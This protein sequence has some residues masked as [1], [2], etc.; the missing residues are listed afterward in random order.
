M[1][2]NARVQDLIRKNEETKHA[3]MD[4]MEKNPGVFQEYERLVEEYNAGVVGIKHEMRST[5]MTGKSVDFGGGFR[6][7]KRVRKGYDA[8][9]LV[10]ICPELVQETGVVTK[11]DTKAVLAAAKL[12]RYQ[13]YNF[14]EA[15]YEHEDTPAAYGPAELKIGL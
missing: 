2:G 8:G 14:D 5:P 4:L 3:L 10:G 7:Q 15:W 12:P 1:T 6:I 13:G 9:V 11:V